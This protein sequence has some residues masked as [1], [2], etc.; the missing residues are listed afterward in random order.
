MVWYGWLLLG[1]Y[2]L[3][4][5]YVWRTTGWEVAAKEARE[6]GHSSIVDGGNITLG[7]LLGFVIAALWPVVVPIRVSYRKGFLLGAGHAFL[8]PPAYVGRERELQ[9]RERHIAELERELGIR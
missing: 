5:V 9:Q 1:L 6:W 4:A 3:V 7:V 2:L 8:R